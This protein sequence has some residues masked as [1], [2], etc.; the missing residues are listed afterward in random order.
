MDSL[1]V[2][3]SIIAILQLLV[4]VLEYLNHVKDDSKDRAQ[5]EIETSNLYS[6][7]INLRCCY[8][9]WKLAGN[10]IYC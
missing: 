5:Y 4:K 2:T 1:S 7:L 8:G 9:Y 3:A 10:C 6:L